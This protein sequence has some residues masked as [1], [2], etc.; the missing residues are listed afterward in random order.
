MKVVF[1]AAIMDCYHQGHENLL[2]KMKAE[3]DWVVVVLHDDKSCYD[4]KGKIPIQTLA[5][6]ME[7]LKIT[8]LVDDIRATYSTDPGPEFKAIIKEYKDSD[9][10][11]MRGDDMMFDFPGRYML[12]RYD[13]PIRFVEYTKGVSSTDIRNEIKIND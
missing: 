7:N 4:I 2:R 12:D 5:H 11:Y 1:A 3:G 9:L 10:L 6:R 8:G 13:V